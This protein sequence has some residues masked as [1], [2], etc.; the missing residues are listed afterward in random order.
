MLAVVIVGGLVLI[1]IDKTTK[2]REFARRTNVRTVLS[3][4]LLRENES[5]GSIVLRRTDVRPGGTITGITQS[6][7]SRCHP[8][9]NGGQI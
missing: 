1:E 6:A 4:P 7:E 3:V 2:A 8:R 9:Q 5:V